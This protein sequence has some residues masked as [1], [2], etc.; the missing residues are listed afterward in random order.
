MDPNKAKATKKTGNKFSRYLPELR[1][2]RPSTVV[3]APDFFPH[4]VARPF[5]EV[6]SKNPP[7]QMGFPVRIPLFRC[8]FFS[9]VVT[10][11]AE[12]SMKT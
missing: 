10:M 9:R 11:F 2:P 1:A 6:P 7:E 8:V 4:W 5:S 12:S 3:L